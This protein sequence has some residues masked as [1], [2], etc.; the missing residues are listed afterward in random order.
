MRRLVEIICAV[1]LM[2]ALLPQ[3]TGCGDDGT[4]VEF[5]QCGDG[6][7]DAG[8]ECDDG[9]VDNDDA[10]LNTCVAATCGDEFVQAGVEQCDGPNLA[11]Q[12]CAT[13]GF[14]TGTLGCTSSCQFDTSQCSGVGP[15]AGGETPT[16]QPTPSAAS[17]E[18]ETPTPGGGEPT[19]TATPGGGGATCRQGDTITIIIAIAYDDVS[20]PDVT[21]GT[22]SVQYPAGLDVP[23]NQS[24]TDQSRAMNLTGTSGGFFNISDQD[25]NGDNVD[26]QVVVGLVGTQVISPGNFASV[27]FDCAADATVPAVGSFTCTPDL[28]T[29]SG[30]NVSGAS[31]NVAA[32]TGP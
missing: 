18:G 13:V 3:M 26:D 16:P 21:G 29:N 22:T 30:T 32:I 31:C 28:A 24:G 19:P 20:F 2:A 7:I 8:E 23:G 12:T 4:R 17:S 9:N 1:L 25:S 27:T 15:T 11:L 6:V 14:A 5:L 10:C